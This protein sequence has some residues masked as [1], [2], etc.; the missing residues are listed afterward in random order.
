M[1]LHKSKLLPALALAAAAAGTF[2][3]AAH[4]VGVNQPAPA[5]SLPREGGGTASLDGLA[6][7]VVYLDFWASWCGPCRQSF[8]WM[9]EIQAKYAARGLRVVA[10]NVDARQSDAEGFL[11]QIPAQFTVAFDPKGDTPRLYQLKGMP[12]SFLINPDGMVLAVHQ[13]FHEEDRKALEASIEAALDAHPE[14]RP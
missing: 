2:V 3:P 14:A 7:H 4:A 9:N 6:G 13:S 1:N 8:P 12:T 5:F 11:A 10:V